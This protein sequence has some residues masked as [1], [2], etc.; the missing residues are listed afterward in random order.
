MRA[1]V[2]QEHGEP[3]DVTEVA[4]P[5]P[6]STA[7]VVEVEA[8]GICR[9]DWHNWQGHWTWLGLDTGPGQII[10]HEAAGTVVEVGDDV[11]HVSVGDRV[12]VPY[13]I[14]DG[15]C[16]W[17]KKGL[18]NRCVNA[19]TLGE[20]ERLQGAY[21]ELL[22]V[23]EADFNIVQLPAYLTSTDVASLGCRFMTAFHGLAHRAAVDGGDWLAI[24]GCGGVGLSAVQ[25]GTAL[26]ANVIAVDIKDGKLELAE[27][28]GATYTVDPAAVDDVPGEIKTL[29]DGGADVSV[30][31]L[32]IEETCR[33]SVDCLG[34]LG[35]H[36]QI[37]LTTSDEEGEIPIPTDRMLVDEQEFITSAGMP[38]ARYDEI[39]NMVRTGKIDPGAVV[40]EEVGLDQVNDK[41]QAMTDYETEGIPVITE[42]SG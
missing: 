10:G 33:N 25:I 27:E 5:E 37:G 39:F 36:V 29:T 28:F 35:T 32:G 6:D 31:A 40:S 20:A 3:L 42:F 22:K 30:D 26:G 13:H 41:L 18:S 1:A 24:H 8:C 2:L 19:E 23:P 17:C 7:A 14:A 16:E 11:E 9:S 38:H 12:A 4:D 15:S 34:V 21:A